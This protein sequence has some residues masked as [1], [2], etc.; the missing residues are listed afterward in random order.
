MGE[1]AGLACGWVL[2]G[3]QEEAGDGG[4][5]L[6]LGCGHWRACGCERRGKGKKKAN[7]DE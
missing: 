2:A 1:W 7:W 6:V 4:W 3:W 5:M